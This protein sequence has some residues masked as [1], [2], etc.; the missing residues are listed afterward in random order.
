MAYNPNQPRD[1]RGRW[2]SYNV[3][4][5][6]R[7]N[8]SYADLSKESNA[9]KKRTATVTELE[10]SLWYEA[11]SNLKRKSGD[12]FPISSIDYCI[13]IDNK[14]FVTGGTFEKPILKDVVAMRKHSVYRRRKKH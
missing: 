2:T 4:V 3:G 1:E 7:Q 8:V 11:I 14:L 6:Y 10:W 5:T 13:K 9:R 12:A